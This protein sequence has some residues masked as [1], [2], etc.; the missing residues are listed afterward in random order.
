MEAQ[1]PHCHV[2]IVKPCGYDPHDEMNQHYSDCYALD[3][4]AKKIALYLL[5]DRGEK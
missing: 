4:L 1:C 3:A 2:R 5:N